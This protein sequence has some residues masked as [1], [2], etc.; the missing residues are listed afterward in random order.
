MSEMNVK[1]IYRYASDIMPGRMSEYMLDGM[2]DRIFSI[3]H[4]DSQIKYHIDKVIDTW[5]AMQIFCL[6]VSD[7]TP[8]TTARRRKRRRG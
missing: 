4:Q 8:N 6:I 5:N 2:T 3:C 1:S 7:R